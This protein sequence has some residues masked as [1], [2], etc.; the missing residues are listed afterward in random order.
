M[1][2]AEAQRWFDLFTGVGFPART[3]LTKSQTR[4]LNK[5]IKVLDQS[6]EK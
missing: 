2:K 5:A 1:T 6:H 3:L 4:L